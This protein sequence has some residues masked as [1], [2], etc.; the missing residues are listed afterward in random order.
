MVGGIN[1]F[2]K[3]IYCFILFGLE[4]ILLP[5]R[6]KVRKERAGIYPERR[7]RILLWD[8]ILRDLGIQKGVIAIDI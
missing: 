5:N 7:F 4:V 6:K 8:A 2:T 3:N 1:I